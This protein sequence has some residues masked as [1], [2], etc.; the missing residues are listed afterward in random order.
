ALIGAYCHGCGQ[1]ALVHR[2]ITAFGHDLLHGIWHFDGKLWRTLPMLLWRPG[3]LTRAYIDGQRARYMSPLSMFLLAVFLTFAVFNTLG[4]GAESTGT[5]DHSVQT[6]VGDNPLARVNIDLSNATSDIPFINTALAKA[7]ENP[8]LMLYKLQN[9][10]Y[11]YAW[12]LIPLSAL[13]LWLLYPF[14]RRFGLYDHLVFVT[15]S[16][17][18]MLLLLVVVRIAGAIGISAILTEPVLVFAPVIHIYRQLRGAYGGTRLGAAWRT[19]AVLLG[20]L[21]ILIAFVVG[22]LALGAWD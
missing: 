12:G 7:R 20:A 6:S 8:S 22:M 1:K 9:A 5:S 14:S 2:S 16:L 13:F 21:L 15:Y 18:F 4:S 10:A 3:E 17:C 11:K 19:V